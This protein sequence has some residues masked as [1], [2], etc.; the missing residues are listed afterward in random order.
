MH[1]VHN[2]WVIMR[3]TMA[4]K[5]LAVICGLIMALWMLTGTARA[6]VLSG[7]MPARQHTPGDNP[8]I[9]A[10]LKIATPTPQPSDNDEIAVPMRSEAG[11]DYSLVIGAIVLVII[12]IAG[13]IIGSRRQPPPK[14]GD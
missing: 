9:P 4:R 1:Y 10:Q 7:S 13:V 2:N 5:K 11:R 8:S 3:K 14:A 6:D 12:V